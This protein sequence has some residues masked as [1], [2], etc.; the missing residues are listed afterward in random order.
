MKIVLACPVKNLGGEKFITS[1]TNLFIRKF[2]SS[3]LPKET[4][5]PNLL[6]LK[7]FIQVRPIFN[8]AC[9]AILLLFFSLFFSFK[10]DAYAHTQYNFPDVTEGQINEALA[11]LVP[12]RFLPD[13]PL[14]FLIT[15]KEA[16]QRF[17]QP[18]AAA[19]TQFDLVLAGKRI[20]EAY[21]AANTGDFKNS[22]RALGSY[23][24][25]LEKLV[26]QFEKARSQNQEVVPL[27]DRIAE[28]LK[29]H[30]IMLGATSEKWQ[31][32]EDAYDFDSNFADAVSGFSNAALAIDNVKPGLKNRFMIVREKESK[33]IILPY[34]TPAGD[35]VIESSPSVR[36]RRIIF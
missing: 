4:R 5:I 7:L 22:S 28:G 3:L 32:Q 25:R 12:L 21:L 19:R 24:K 30:E 18:S 13:H 17:F 31:G 16:V 26:W 34:V 9:L 11:R 14:Y 15:T 20:K 8:G 23:Q 1:V 6:T 2:F 29:D 36:P 35:F 33:N 27:A 10:T